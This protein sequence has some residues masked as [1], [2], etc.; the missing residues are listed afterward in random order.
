MVDMT[1]TSHPIAQTP[2]ELT[3]LFVERAN[4]GDL[5]GLV[6]LYAPDAV[7]AFPPGSASVGHDAIRAVLAQM[8]DH[9][10]ATGE[11]FE[12]EELLPTLRHGDVALT[13][14]KPRD[15]TGGRAQVVARQADGSWLRIIDRPEAAGA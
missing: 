6:A 12:Q 9:V 1:T 15:G 10:S 3:R 11:R 7:L 4:A 13:A 5:D 14:T 8:L 2:E